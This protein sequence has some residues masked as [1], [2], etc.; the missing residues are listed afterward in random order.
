[1]LL[2]IL[3]GFTLGHVNRILLEVTE[4]EPAILPVKIPKTFDAAI[5]RLEPELGN[6]IVAAEC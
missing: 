3:Q 1:M 6:D 4:P 2:E 5:V